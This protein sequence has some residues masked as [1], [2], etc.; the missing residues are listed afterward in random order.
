MHFYVGSK[1]ENFNKIQ[2]CIA[3]RTTIIPFNVFHKFEQCIVLRNS[4]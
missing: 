1:R 3:L 4:Y 2:Q